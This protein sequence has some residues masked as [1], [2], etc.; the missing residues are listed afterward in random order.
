VQ[1][2]RRPRESRATNSRSEVPKKRVRISAP[3]VVENGGPALAALAIT[4]IA[5]SLAG[6]KLS[7]GFLVSWGVLF[8]FILGIV[9]W[10]L[11][12]ILV[13]KDRL[14]TLSVWTGSIVALLALA[15]VIGYVIVRG[16]AVVFARFPHFWYADMSQSG[17][18]QPVTAVG[19]GAAIVGTVE[20]VAIASIISIPIGFL[21]ATYLV[22]SKS[23]LSRIVRNVV[24]AMTG[25]PSIIAGLFIYLLWVVPHKQG[26]KSGFAAGVTLAVLMLPL[27]TRAAVE[28]IRIVPGSLREAALAL[29]AP[30]WR[31]VLRVVMP[32]AKIGLITAGILGVART[33]GET[34]EVLFTAGGNSHLNLNP[35]H[36]Q[37]DDLPLR[38]F[39]LVFQPSTNAIKEAWG[40]S[41]VLVAVVLALFVTA[42]LIGSQRSWGLPRALRR[43]K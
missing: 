9:H 37:Q 38:V 28:V 41:F 7:F 40:V 13:M 14:A 11:H 30:Q 22:E 1:Q 42:R 23:V 43:Q 29:G 4:W 15:A 21:T 20:Q 19:A 32:T 33:A 39:Q 10:R 26:G 25:T 5:F 24:D 17:G 8:Y 12:G 31:V 2:G 27:V 36:G 16:A 34:A 6:E 35:F 18:S 3:T